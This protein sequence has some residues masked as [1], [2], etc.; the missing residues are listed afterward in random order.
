MPTLR[1]LIV[2]DEELI[3]SGIRQ[4][5][6]E[7]DDVE[8][9]GECATGAEAVAGIDELRPDVVLLDIRMPDCSGI[10]V[11]RAVGP[12]RMPAVVFVTAFD[13]YA[14]DAF[15]LD[16]V[17]Y[18][19]KPFDEDRLRAS[20]ER[21]RERIGARRGAPDEQLARLLAR[22][23]TAH[24]ERVVVRNGERYEF[25]PVET[26]DWIESA[27][28]CVELHCGTRRLLLSE[29]LTHLEQRLDPRRFLRVH[30]CRVVN[31][32]RIAA[33]HAMIGGTCEIELRGGAKV[34]T[35]RRYRE[36]ICRPWCSRTARGR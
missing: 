21:V 27:N 32:A 33:V 24:A 5:L 6:A 3:R 18:L 35:G 13:E 12:G 4:M 20:L 26:I 23:E 17:D 1:V 31:V 11:V 15:E 29:G 2:D 28:A 7:A 8:V 14:V 34:A 10:E 16:A 22:L 30:R 36:V 25:V 9:V 19:L